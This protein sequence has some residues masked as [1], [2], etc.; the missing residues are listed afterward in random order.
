[1][2]VAAVVQAR[3]GSTRFPGKVLATLHGR[4]LLEHVLDRAGAARCADAVVLATTTAMGDDAVADL[5]ERAGVVVFRG[6]E[7]DVLQRFVMAAASVDADVVVRLTGD[8]PLLDPR[9]IDRVVRALLE[10]GSEY[11]G[12]VAP[13]TYPDGYDVE[14]LTVA[15]LIRLDREA[16][17]EYEREHVTARAREHPESYR[18]AAVACRRDLSRIRLTVDTPA[19]LDRIDRI[20]DHFPDGALPGLG[21][22]LGVLSR[23]PGLLEGA[24]ST[25]RDEKYIAQRMAEGD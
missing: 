10:S 11:A 3:A 25:V 5:G 20:L 17:R 8:C 13:P 12:N 9:M 22:V 1:M 2:R 16:A 21:A 14:A 24:A 7:E 6:P 19:D 23:H 18:Q 15:C 4:A